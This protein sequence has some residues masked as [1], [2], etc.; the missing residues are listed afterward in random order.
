MFHRFADA[1]V[2]H[3]FVPAPAPLPPHPQTLVGPGPMPP[4]RK[5][6]RTTEAI[7]EEAKEDLSS[8]TKALG[9]MYCRIVNHITERI[10]GGAGAGPGVSAWLMASLGHPAANPD[11]GVGWAQAM[12]QLLNIQLTTPYLR[13]LD[14]A[15]DGVHK[16]APFQLCWHSAAGYSTASAEEELTMICLVLQKGFQSDPTAGSMACIQMWGA[17]M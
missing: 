7:T 10:N 12:A 3:C 15:P 13:S 4:A 8:R 2:P 16:L 14:T 5:R 17:P 1:K 6:A 11:H 9:E